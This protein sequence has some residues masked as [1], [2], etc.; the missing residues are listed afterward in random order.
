[1]PLLDRLAYSYRD[2]P[3]VGRFDDSRPLFLFDGICVLCS[4]GVRFLM[5]R[6]KHG[7]IRFASAQSRLGQS[8]YAHFGMPIDESY[9]LVAEG[10]AYT[11]SDGYFR[12]LR[13]LGGAWPILNGLRAIPR[14]VRD[15]AYDRMAENRYSWFGKT[16]YCALLTP[17]QQRRLIDR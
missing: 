8:L 6:D 12:L 11:K 3:S 4:S 13:D 2:D 16:E 15:W 7:S 9:L 17:E 5:R 1:M 10:R 14:I